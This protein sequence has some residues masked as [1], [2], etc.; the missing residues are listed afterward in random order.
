MKKT[1]NMTCIMCPMGCSLVVEKVGDEIKVSGNTC[2][3]GD[4]YAREEITEPKRIVTAL[5]RT[6]FGVLPVKTTKPVPKNMIFEVV[7]EINKLNLKKGKMGDIIIKNVLNTGA[8]VVITG[9]RVDY[10]I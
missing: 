3:R 2:I 9:N 6:S 8:D 10:G 4:N 5:V 1:M 7:G